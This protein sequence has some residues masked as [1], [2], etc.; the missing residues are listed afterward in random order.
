MNKTQDLSPR[1]DDALAR[2]AFTERAYTLADVEAAIN[3]DA[4]RLGSPVACAFLQQPVEANHAQPHQ[5][6]V[7]EDGEEGSL[8]S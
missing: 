6:R 3:A 8:E 4:Q 5:R 7:P 2:T 1:N